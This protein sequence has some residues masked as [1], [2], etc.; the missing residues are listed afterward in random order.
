M[1]PATFCA[2]CRNPS[3]ISGGAIWSGE[4][5]ARRRGRGGDA[6]VDGGLGHGGSDLVLPAW[7]SVPGDLGGLAKRERFLRV[8][9]RRSTSC[10][11]RRE[12]KV[13][14][15]DNDLRHDLVHGR[16]RG[17]DG[18]LEDGSKISAVE[19]GGGLAFC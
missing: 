3:V 4:G 5:C 16:G 2:Q 6:Q 14:S 8:T 10:R 12:C 11:R 17:Q 1:L 7:W 18:S 9:R 19:D 13:E 15:A